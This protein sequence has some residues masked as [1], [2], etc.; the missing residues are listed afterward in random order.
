MPQ[1]GDETWCVG[2]LI[3][4]WGAGTLWSRRCRC[5]W[6]SSGLV[7]STTPWL[8]SCRSA[9]LV[10]MSMLVGLFW[11][12]LV[13]MS[14][15]SASWV[16]LG[17]SVLTLL[18]LYLHIL[19]I[20]AANSFCVPDKPLFLVGCF[21]HV[22]RVFWHVCMSGGLSL[23]KQAV[24]STACLPAFLVPSLVP[25]PVATVPWSAKFRPLPLAL[26]IALPPGYQALLSLKFQACC[27][28]NTM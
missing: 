4:V 17:M 24:A 12:M 9:M 5:C 1:H 8:T 22:C 23:C 25:C 27:V 15:D 2:Q 11:E 19:L 26:Q 10:G 28:G 13:R 20:M 6:G 14:N 7:C 3:V 21:W 18:F 16:L